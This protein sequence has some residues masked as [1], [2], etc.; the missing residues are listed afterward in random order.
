MSKIV[1]HAET[2]IYYDGPALFEARDSRGGR[3]LGMAVDSDNDGD[4][5]AVF[6]VSPERLRLFINGSLDLF[7]LIAEREN[8]TWYV[9]VSQDDDSGAFRLI[10]QDTPLTETEYMPDPGLFLR[11]AETRG[12]SFSEPVDRVHGNAIGKIVYP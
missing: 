7:G 11:E 10:K 6:A 4:R 3:Y 12:E 1:Q 5:Y 9:G 8:Q 2:L